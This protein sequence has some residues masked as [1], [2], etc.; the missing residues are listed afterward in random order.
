MAPSAA[1]MLLAFAAVNRRRRERQAPYVPTAVFLL[2]YVI[3]WT[4]FSV[5]ATA[6]Q[7]LLQAAALLSPALVSTSPVFGAGLLI[8][9]GVFQWTPLKNRCLTQCH[10]PLHF[11]MVAWREGSRGAFAMGLRHGI[12]CLGCCWAVMALLF[13]AGVMNLLWVAT[14][15][16]FVLLE[17]LA[18]RYISRGGGA[19]MILAGAW[20]LLL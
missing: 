12:Y 6:V 1:P 14:L 8:T 7:F 16:V 10:S 15:S 5:V 4:G 20:L 13:V 19:L 17:K 3:V 18:P 9:A 2:G 11:I